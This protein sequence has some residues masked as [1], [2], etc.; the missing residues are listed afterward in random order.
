MQISYKRKSARLAEKFRNPQ[1][2]N[3]IRPVKVEKLGEIAKENNCQGFEE[4]F[5]NQ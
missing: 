3:Q 2:P 4:I 5:F 1:R